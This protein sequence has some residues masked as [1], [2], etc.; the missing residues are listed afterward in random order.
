MYKGSVGKTVLN[1]KKFKLFSVCFQHN[2]ESIY[3]FL[4]SIMN[5]F[6]TT[7]QLLDI[8]V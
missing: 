8:V 6:T 2:I 5:S 3:L 7:L 4:G 1:N